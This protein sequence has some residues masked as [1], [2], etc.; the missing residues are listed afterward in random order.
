[1][2]TDE[3]D[4]TDIYAIATGPEGRC[5][6]VYGDRGGYL[7]EE[8]ALTGPA[9]LRFARV[10]PTLGAAIDAAH[11]RH[12]DRLRPVE[13]PARGG[14]PHLSEEPPGGDPRPGAVPPTEP[15]PVTPQTRV[16]WDPMAEARRCRFWL[17]EFGGRE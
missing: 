17:H 6:L 15:S 4:A 14:R 13:D 5:V 7:L 16:H 3:S 11:R 9:E 10:Y 1:M 12:P 2:T 8:Y